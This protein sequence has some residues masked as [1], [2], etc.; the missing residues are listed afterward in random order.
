MSSGASS[1]ERQQNADLPSAL[2][3]DEDEEFPELR[4]HWRQ[5]VKDYTIVQNEIKTPVE[6]LLT[7]TDEEATLFDSALAKAKPNDNVRG[8]QEEEIAIAM[9]RFN[10]LEKFAP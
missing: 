6:L 1:N 5:Q 2:S 7:L 9:A 4:D 3:R 10:K 8:T